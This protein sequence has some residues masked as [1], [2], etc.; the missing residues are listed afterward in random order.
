MFG[1]QGSS[2]QKEM[3]GWEPLWGRLFSTSWS[4]SGSAASSP[5][6]YVFTFDPFCPLFSLLELCCSKTKEKKCTDLMLW[7]KK[8][9]FKTDVNL[10]RM[11]SAFS[12]LIY[13]NLT[14]A[15]KQ[16]CKIFFFVFVARN[17]IRCQGG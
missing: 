5:D 3:L 16:K 10:V 4:S 7:E 17:K 14:S 12:K 2:S 11:K 6:K 13:L 9:F 15:L 8:F 1:Y